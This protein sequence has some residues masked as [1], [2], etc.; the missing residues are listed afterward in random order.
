MYLFTRSAR[1]LL[2]RTRDLITWSVAVTEKVNQ[3]SQTPVNLWTTAFSPGVGTLV[4]TSVIEDLGTLEATDSK[5]AADDGYLALADEGATFAS[6][7][8]VDDH[9]IQVIHNEGDPSAP[10]PAYAAVVNAMLAPGASARGI[11]LGVE[12]AQRAQ[13]ITGIPTSFGV[14]VTG[15]YGMVTWV[16]GADSVDQLQRSQEATAGDA[17]FSKLVDTQGG[18][19]YLAGSAIQVIYRKLL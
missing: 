15:P 18:A 3:I 13:A 1:P 5:L 17:E 8:P 6:N 19:A 4:W 16:T 12:I 7:D 10:A 14:G 11:E 2:G 9:L